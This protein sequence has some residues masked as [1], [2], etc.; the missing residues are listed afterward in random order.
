MHEVT[1]QE[2]S[3]SYEIVQGLIGVFSFPTS[4]QW[5]KNQHFHVNELSQELNWLLQ[6]YRV[7]KILME[8]H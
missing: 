6:P 3:R 1:S 4:L 5:K 8:F 2:L 7:L